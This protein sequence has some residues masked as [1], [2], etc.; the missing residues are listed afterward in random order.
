MVAANAKEETINGVQIVN[1]STTK[2]KRLGR[3]LFTAREVYRK[4]RSIDADIYHFHDPELL[5]YVAKLKRK[6]KIVIYD[7]HEDLPRQIM[8]KE[9]LRFKKTIAKIVEWYENKVAQKVDAVVAATPFIAARFQ[10]INPTSKAINNFPLMS[11]IDF[12][13][14][15]QDDVTNTICFIGNISRIRGT[16]EL[17]DSLQY[18]DATLDLAGEIPSDL[19]QSLE[20]SKGWKQVNELGYIDRKT[21]LNIKQKA[22]AGIVTFL[23][24]PNHI[25]AQP[26]KIFEYMAAEL[27]VIGSNF[28]LWKELIEGNKC[29]ILSLI[30]I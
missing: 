21:A 12:S 7:A 30:H 17:V 18:T 16:Q 28:P 15:A 23:P 5:P 10:K 1:G 14:R 19:R 8:G 11:E 29:G 13:G 2:R 27:P 26:N 6:N 4:A 25:D 22:V 20:H 3:M 9:Y 24:L